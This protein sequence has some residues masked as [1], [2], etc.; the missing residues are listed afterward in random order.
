MV[1]RRYCPQRVVTSQDP[2][3]AGREG[4]CLST[5]GESPG[6]SL[7]ERGMRQIGIASHAQPLL[8]D[9]HWLPIDALAMEEPQAE[10]KAGPGDTR[11]SVLTSVLPIT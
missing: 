7:Q 3:S 6:H 8:K 4:C 9:L 5:E 1:E 10:G 11:V 2:G